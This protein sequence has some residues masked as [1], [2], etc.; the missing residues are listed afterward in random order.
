MVANYTA[1]L[2]QL[3]AVA[4][5]YHLFSL[6]TGLMLLFFTALS[7]LTGARLLAHLQ[8]LDRC[9]ATFE[10]GRA[11]VKEQLANNQ[12]PPDRHRRNPPD[13]RESAAQKLVFLD[14]RRRRQL[15]WIEF[16]GS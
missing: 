5:P 14:R 15:L 2:E 11:L 12:L 7:C 10:T 9:A 6:S 8:Q 4:K 1:R 3:P 16:I 13:N